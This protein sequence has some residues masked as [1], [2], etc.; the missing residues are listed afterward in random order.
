MISEQMNLN[1]I[2]I[3]FAENFLIFQKHWPFLMILLVRG[4]T[5]FFFL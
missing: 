5:R 3:S 1:T 4:A 2:R